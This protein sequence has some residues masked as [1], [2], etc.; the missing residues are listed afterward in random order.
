MFT[1]PQRPPKD[2]KLKEFRKLQRSG[3][4]FDP[5]ALPRVTHKNF[6]IFCEPIE[7]KDNEVPDIKYEPTNPALLGRWANK[8]RAWWVTKPGI[9]DKFVHD[10]FKKYNVENAKPVDNQRVFLRPF[11]FEFECQHQRRLWRLH[12]KNKR[13]QLAFERPYQIKVAKK[14]AREKPKIYIEKCKADPPFWWKEVKEET[15]NQPVLNAE[16]E[17]VATEA[18]LDEAIVETWTEVPEYTE[19]PMDF[20]ERRREMQL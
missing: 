2:Y 15:L 7:Y 1:L 19:K 13:D 3:D 17:H 18:D 6:G 14:I 5:C 12:R 20:C 4:A 16:Q 10:L 8:E 11:Y 9:D